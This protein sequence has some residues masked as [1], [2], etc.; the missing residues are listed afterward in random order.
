M[1]NRWP[2]IVVTTLCCL[3]TVATSASA[4]CAWMMW[5]E[6]TG[7]LRQQTERVWEVYDTTDTQEVC[8]AR[9]PA[10]REAMAITLR[11]SGDEVRVLPGGTVRRL[12]KNGAEIFYRFQCLPDTVDPRGPKG[13]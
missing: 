7:T 9:L 3:L 1:T 11:E 2:C 4:E 12:R 5:M 10:A 13:K 6:G 8:K